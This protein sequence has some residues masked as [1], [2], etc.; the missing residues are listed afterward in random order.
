MPSCLSLQSLP[1]GSRPRQWRLER[2]RRSPRGC[3]SVRTDVVEGWHHAPFHQTLVLP[4]PEPWT[5]PSPAK[6]ET[7]PEMATQRSRSRSLSSHEAEWSLLQHLELHLTL[8]RRVTKS[9]WRR[10]S[11][12]LGCASIIC[13]PR[14]LSLAS[15]IGHS[16]RSVGMRVEADF[17]PV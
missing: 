6:E 11:E 8:K 13:T 15:A 7:S 14:L 10:G 12:V 5:C 16:D 2:R 9:Q 17:Y 3:S 1:V 4:L